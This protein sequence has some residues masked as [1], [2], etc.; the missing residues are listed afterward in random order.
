M[1][2]WELR[3]LNEPATRPASQPGGSAVVSADQLRYPLSS[4][5][6]RALKMRR[7]RRNWVNIRQRLKAC[8]RRLS[9]ALPQ[10]LMPTIYWGGSTLR[11]TNTLRRRNPLRKPRDSCRTNPVTTPI[12]DYRWRFSA[13]GTAP[14]KSC[15]S[16]AN[17]IARMQRR[18]RF[19][20]RSECGSSTEPWTP[21]L[22]QI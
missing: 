6:S 2:A 1:Y 12:W 17:W 9:S 15:A 18:N 5:A 11:A 21:K 19:C 8:G 13:N 3:K 7:A 4:K 10:R 14:N 22:V 16:R 20:K